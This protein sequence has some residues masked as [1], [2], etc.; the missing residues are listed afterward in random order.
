MDTNTV[1]TIVDAVESEIVLG[2][3]LPGTPLQQEELAE[4][5]GVSRQPVRTALEILGA[6]KLVSRRSDR[7]IE[8]LAISPSTS[9]EILAIRRIL[10]PEALSLAFDHLNDRDMLTARQALEQFEIEPDYKMLAK[11]DLEFHMALYRPSGNETLL[12]LIQELRKTNLRSYLG[13]PLGSNARAAC[14]DAHAAIL[15][16]CR[17]KDKKQ[18]LSLLRAHFDISK[19]R[20]Q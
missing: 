12:Q 1:D 19:V 8:V 10:E 7:T 5:F 18:A 4:R 16:A 11:F 15:A 20:A 2:Q 3:L 13:Q 6:R 9:D 17:D 14:I